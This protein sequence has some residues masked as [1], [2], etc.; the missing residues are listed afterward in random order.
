MKHIHE[1]VKRNPTILFLHGNA[2]TRAFHA[3]VDHYK[4]FT[5]RLSV[6]VLA[7]DYRGFADSTGYPTESGVVRDARA[8]WDWLISQGTK[9]E[10]ILIVGH[11]LGTGIGGRLA[12]DLSDEGIKYRGLVLMS[13]FSSI[14]EV[15][16]TYHILGVVPL[17]KPLALIP[18][19]A[20]KSSSDSF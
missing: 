12:A 5:S 2:A 3:R 17:M 1:A 15:L 16:K 19:A 14:E 11:S 13:P 4:T 7:V 9:G 8:A 18:G 6:N 20:S 10:D